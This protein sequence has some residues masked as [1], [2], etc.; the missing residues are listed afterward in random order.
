MTEPAAPGRSCPLHYRYRPDV[1]RRAADPGCVALEVLYVV[2]G[3]YGHAGALAQIVSLFDAEAGRKRLVFNGDF[4][5]F[6]VEPVA[7][8]ALNTTVLD[9]DALRGNVETEL[10]D[11]EAVHK[12]SDERLASLTL[13]LADTSGLNRMQVWHCSMLL[14]SARIIF[15]VMRTPIHSPSSCL[16]STNVSL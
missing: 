6:D 2:G 12:L 4:N 8:E 11:P 14:L 9:F 3:L 1:F 10:A 16:Y 7:F 5:W 13:L 15:R